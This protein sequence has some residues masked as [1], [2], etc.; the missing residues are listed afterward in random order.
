MNINSFYPELNT[1]L[2]T[3]PL[4][5]LPYAHF[6]IT[7][8]DCRL[9]IRIN[10]FGDYEVV[11]EGWLPFGSTKIL[12]SQYTPHSRNV[13]FASSNFANVIKKFYT[14]MKELLVLSADGIMHEVNNCYK[15]EKLPF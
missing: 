9:Y 7:V 8:L 1:P 5:S 3:L 14:L 4:R 11:T 15:Q 13:V 6:Y 10:K 2:D 12:L